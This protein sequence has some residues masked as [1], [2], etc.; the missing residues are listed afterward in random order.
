[1][2]DLLNCP[3]E[4]DMRKGKKPKKIKPWLGFGWTFD[5]RTY[6]TAYECGCG[7]RC[8]RDGHG[9]SRIIFCPACR[10][11]REMMGVAGYKS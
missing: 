8:Q 1:M 3:P 2:T 9:F 11:P 10:E 6:R 4:A 7:W 5:R